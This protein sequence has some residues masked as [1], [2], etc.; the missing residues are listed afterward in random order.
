MNQFS[1][2]RA[3]PFLPYMSRTADPRR[4]EDILTAARQTFERDG[5]GGA[6]MKDIAPGARRAVGALYLY[7]EWKD[8]L[9]RARGGDPFARAGLPIFETLDKPLTRARVRLLVNRVF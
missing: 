4:R 2:R 1:N 6:G 5:F 7:C 3:T 8:A 9:A